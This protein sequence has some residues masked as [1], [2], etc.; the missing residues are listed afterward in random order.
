MLPKFTS[1]KAL[2][3]WMD[4]KD[5][6]LI[7]CYQ[8]KVTDYSQLQFLSDLKQLPEAILDKAL[9]SGRFT[10]SAISFT[11][12]LKGLKKL[13]ATVEVQAVLIALT[14][15]INASTVELDGQNIGNSLYGLQNMDAK[16]DA[17][18]ALLF[19]LTNKVRASHAKLNSQE[20]GN[21]LYGLQ[22]MDAKSDAV[23]ALLFALTHKVT[24]SNAK[25]NSQ[26]LGNALYGLQNMDAKSDAV[27]ALL[28]AL[29]HKVNTSYAELN[30]QTI[31][32]ALY[33]LQNMDAK[34]DAVLALLFA[35]AHKVQASHAELSGQHI[36]NALYGLQNMDAKSDAVQALLFALTH[37]VTASNAKLNSQELG[38]ALYGLQNMG[39]FKELPRL[40]EQLFT[41]RPADFAYENQPL[42]W[43]MTVSSYL[44]LAKNTTNEAALE[45]ICRHLKALFPTCNQGQP[46]QVIKEVETLF[47]NKL[48]LKHLNHGIVDLH[49]LDY[50]SAS[51]LL[52]EGFKDTTTVNKIIFGAGNHSAMAHKNAMK[53]VVETY[54]SNYGLATKHWEKGCVQLANSTTSVSSPPPP[55]FFLLEKKADETK[56]MGWNPKAQVF[57][58]K[59]EIKH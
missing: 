44:K 34:R 49:S 13:P 19:A 30:G 27:Q 58:P 59:N 33:G 45:I 41:K 53:T 57:I 10:W 52:N 32:N 9:D 46:N 15:K 31:G 5:C 48:K 50:L 43:S 2:S 23:Q 36:G 26:E 12:C 7:D 4:D 35:L 20:L 21:A 42:G 22:N 47:V 11:R 17:V 14:S 56:K 51:L 24:A 54:C 37:K 1:A 29:A 38:N 39:D 28:F 16:S 55:P 3:D 25:L 6:P 8:G 18:Q 40:L